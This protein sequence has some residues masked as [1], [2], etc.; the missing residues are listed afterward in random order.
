[1]VT[2]VPASGSGASSGLKRLISFA[3]PALATLSWG[4]DQAGNVR[5]GG[6]QVHLLL[7]ARFRALALLAVHRDRAA[8]GH[9]PGIPAH[10]GIEPWMGRVR[11]EPAVL[12][13]LPEGRRSRR[14]LFPLL[15]P[16]PLLCLLFGAVRG[17]RGRDAGIQRDPGHGRRDSG[18][19]L[20]GIEQEL[21]QPVQH[22]RRRRDPLPGPRAHPAAMRGQN[23]LAPARRCQRRLQRPAI[24]ARRGPGRH[25]HQGHQF[26]PLPPVLP[27]IG[28]PPFQ[29]LPER[30]RIEC[31]S[32]GQVAAKAVS[33]PR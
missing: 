32:R 29:R 16:F 21:S 22:R 14:L 28:Q 24:P 27:R 2:T 18:L 23:L 31:R 30:D 4:D 13:L 17:I 33:K 6:E 11:P 9:V 5:D 10:S 12:A 20:V 8:R 7:P 3:L 25:R 26:M 15:P 19:E 1:M